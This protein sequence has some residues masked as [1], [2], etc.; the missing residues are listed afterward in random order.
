MSR[1]ELSSES[2]RE[3]KEDHIVLRKAV[4]GGDSPAGYR[5]YMGPRPNST[6]IPKSATSW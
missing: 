4:P 2:R 5:R 1:E 6:T 3:R